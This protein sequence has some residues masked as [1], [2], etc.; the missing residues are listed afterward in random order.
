[1]KGLWASLLHI[2]QAASPLPAHPTQQ[3]QLPG[4]RQM[5]TCMQHVLCHKTTPVLLVL[6]LSQAQEA[7]GMTQASSTA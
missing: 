2:Q 3:P 5:C 7:G 6:L 1:M 4:G